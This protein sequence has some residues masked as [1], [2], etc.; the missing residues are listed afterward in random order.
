MSKTLTQHLG[1]ADPELGS[2]EHDRMV[3]Q[4]T[5]S[6]T[7]LQ[8]LRCAWPDVLSRK[9]NG[10]R[11]ILGVPTSSMPPV[12]GDRDDIWE[13]VTQISLEKPIMRKNYVVGFVDLEVTVEWGK[14]NDNR[15]RAVFYIEVKTNIKSVGKLLRQINLYRTFVPDYRPWVVFC[16][17][18]RYRDL[19]ESQG[20]ALVTPS[21][22]QSWAI[23]A[24]KQGPINGVAPLRGNDDDYHTDDRR[25]SQGRR[26]QN[27]G[28]NHDRAWPGT[29]RV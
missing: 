4:L 12:K 8:V 15:V 13:R 20:I 21:A 2:P 22:L 5:N 16:N 7:M 29:D 25:R 17:H 24:E 26:R 14:G 18:D 10:T 9:R 23:E 28:C 3:T 1:F 6:D 27:D 11:A 19:L